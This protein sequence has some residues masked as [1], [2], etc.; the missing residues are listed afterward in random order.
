MKEKKLVMQIDI[1]SSKTIIKIDEDNSQNLILRKLSKGV[2]VLSVNW[3]KG[4]N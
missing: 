2:M 4:D 1:D 3:R